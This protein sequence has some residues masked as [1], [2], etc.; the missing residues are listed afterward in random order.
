MNEKLVRKELQEHGIDDNPFDLAFYFALELAREFQ[1]AGRRYRNPDVLKDV[2]ISD[3]S[4]EM[5]YN[6]LHEQREVLKSLSDDTVEF[7]RR[8]AK[9][10]RDY[11]TFSDSND[12]ILDIEKSLNTKYTQAEPC[13]DI[14][15]ERIRLG[16][17]SEEY[18]R[19]ITLIK[20]V[21]DNISWI[22]KSKL[23]DMLEIIDK[24]YAGCL[25]D[26]EYAMVF[27]RYRGFIYDNSLTR[28]DIFYIM[29]VLEQEEI[30]VK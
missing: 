4:I 5:W 3:H 11:K 24:G 1:F 30:N 22:N 12:A 15:Y 16:G 20:L 8:Y 25:V 26:K 14:Y 19:M 23:Y 21:R 17:D 9:M 18:K 10:S 28:E 29:S 7:L 13:R 6:N 27:D 2:Q